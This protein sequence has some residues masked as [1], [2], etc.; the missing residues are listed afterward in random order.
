MEVTQKAIILDRYKND[1]GQR[2]CMILTEHRC[3]R[4]EM[5]TE[6]ETVLICNYCGEGLDLYE[7]SKDIKPSEFCPLWS[8]D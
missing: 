5:L 2:T 1:D 3:F 4:C 6:R 8:E 7:D